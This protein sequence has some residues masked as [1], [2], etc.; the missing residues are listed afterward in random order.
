MERKNTINYNELNTCF[1]IIKNNMINLKFKVSK[2]DEANW[3]NNIVNNLIKQ[4][5]FFYLL[6]SNNKICGFVI[7]VYE[8]NLTLHEIQLSDNVKRTRVLY[9][10][11]KYLN[12]SIGLKNF[13]SVGFS[14]LK[15]NFISIKTFTHLGAKLVKETENKYFYT[16]E[17]LALEQYF[18]TNK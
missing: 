12:S 17:R 8:N 4:N 18:A 16:L 6:Y 3:K 9:Y 15:H 10:T 2:Q 1:N 14:I 7:L 13:N 11:L 5:Y